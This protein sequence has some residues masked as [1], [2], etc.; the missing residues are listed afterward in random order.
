MKLYD[1]LMTLKKEELYD[2]YFRV[3]LVRKSYD[4]ITR[5]KMTEE[6][7][8]LYQQPR[9]LLDLCTAK[10]LKLIEQLLN[11]KESDSDK[12]KKLFEDNQELFFTLSSKALVNIVYTETPTL[13]EDTID[14]QKKAFEIVDWKVVAFND[15]INEFLVGFYKIMGKLMID[16]AK[17]LT[18]DVLG[19]KQEYIENHIDYNALFNFYVVLVYETLPSTNEE[20]M[21]GIYI[22]YKDHI[23]ELEQERKLQASSG[24]VGLNLDRIKNIFYYDYDKDNPKIS[25]LFDLFKIDYHTYSIFRIMVQTSVL[26]NND[27]QIIKSLF[28]NLPIVDDKFYKDICQAIDEAMDDMPSAALNGLTPNEAKQ[29]RNKQAKLN[30]EK[31]KLNVKQ[32]FAHLSQKDADLYYKIYFGLLDFTNKKYNIKPGLRIYQT[33]SINPQQLTEILERFWQKNKTITTEFC[34]KNPYNFN[35]EELKI[36]SDFKKGFREPMIIARYFQEYTGIVHNEDLY[37]VKGI[38]T[39]F[40]TFINKLDIPM[41]VITALVPF[42]NVIVFDSIIQQFPI[43]IDADTQEYVEKV[44]QTAEKIYRLD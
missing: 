29:K 42:K 28:K 10:E 6:I 15:R 32:K 16:V 5:K 19:L 9:F 39:N 3:S 37:M 2:F 31:S 17:K 34:L 1:Y 25:E 30:I 27:R 21:F 41:L 33:K 23:D 8:E 35:S 40:D 26:L 22:D 7:L 18:A 12:A 4:S 44:V 43:D 13:F 14:A 11:F 20:R 38:R 36:A 24:Q